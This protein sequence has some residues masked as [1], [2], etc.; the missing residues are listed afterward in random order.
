M[1]SNGIFAFIRWNF[2]FA[3]PPLIITEQQMQDAL[4]VMND[5]LAIADKYTE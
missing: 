3:V 2:L 5:A 1:R 4:N